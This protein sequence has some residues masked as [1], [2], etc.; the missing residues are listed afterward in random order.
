MGEPRAPSV[1][2]GRT[3]A[4]P[5]MTR[6]ES[7]VSDVESTVSEVGSKDDISSFVGPSNIKDSGLL[8]PSTSVASTPVFP[9]TVANSMFPPPPID[10]EK[11]PSSRR[12]SFSGSNAP[13]SPA[14]SI[15]S[16]Y[17]RSPSP[18]PA[19]P[20]I[21]T[22]PRQQ[23]DRWK[24]VGLYGDESYT[25]FFR[26][27]TFSPD[28]GLL[29][30]PAGQ[31]EDPEIISKSE[32]SQRGRKARLTISTDPNAAPVDNNS[33]VY[34]YT[35][36]NFAS[37]PVAQLPGFQKASVAVKFNPVLF[38]LRQGVANGESGAPKTAAIGKGIEGSLNVDLLAPP[39]TT[40]VPES[41]S[42]SPSKA[43]IVAPAPMQ[44]SWSTST[45]MSDS[46]SELGSPMVGPRT[47][48]RP[49]TP[50]ASKPS[51][52]MPAPSSSQNA[53]TTG[54][55]FALPYRMLFAVETMD[56]V[57]IYDTQQAGPFCM[58]TKLHYD[59]FTDLSW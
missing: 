58:L 5:E 29:I 37:P 38:Q 4:R 30:T 34:I 15:S 56:T 9:P 21:R 44:G 11:Q 55:V 22:A 3:G 18:M 57:A 1:A 31:F 36:A 26:R 25:N 48:T 13:S 54:S 33:C 12:S 53:L 2:R 52:P 7:V 10:K 20:A 17:A 23:D 32:D 49:P 43:H 41:I 27:L 42:A 50:V 6:R 35:R 51:T 8:T 46:N 19:L 16:R 45:M 40:T 39:T 14:F 24:Q 28:G 59:E 47:S